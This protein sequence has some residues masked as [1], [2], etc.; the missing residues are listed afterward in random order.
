MIALLVMLARSLYAQ[1]YSAE[2]I[3]VLLGRKVNTVKSV[4]RWVSWKTNLVR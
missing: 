1:G 2:E 4:I 3:A